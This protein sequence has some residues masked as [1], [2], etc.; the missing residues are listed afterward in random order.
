MGL[1]KIPARRYVILSSLSPEALAKGEAKSLPLR[2][3]SGQALPVPVTPSGVE[4]SIAEGSNA[5]GSW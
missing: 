2:F 3:H 4:G 1:V 5:K